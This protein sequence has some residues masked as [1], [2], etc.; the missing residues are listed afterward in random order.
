[1][2][3][4]QGQCLQ[5]RFTACRRAG[6]GSRGARCAAVPQ[7]TAASAPWTT[8]KWMWKDHTINYAVAGCGDPV[9]LIHGFGANCTQWR[10]TIAA[11]SQEHKVYA[12]DLLGFGGSEKAPIDYSIELWAEQVRDFCQEFAQTP[13]T[14][15]GNSIGSLVSLEAARMMESD[16]NDSG[17]KGLALINCAGGMNNKARTDDWRVKVALPLFLLIDFVLKTRFIAKP[18]FDSFRTE[19]NVRQVLQNVYCNPAE[20][21]DELVESICSPSDDPGALDVLVSVFT[22]PP[23]PKPEPLLETTET[24]VLILWGDTDPLT[25]VDGPVGQFCQQ[26]PDRRQNIQFQLLTGAG[27]C[28]MDDSPGDVHKFLLPWLVKTGQD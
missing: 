10:K 16:P 22:G 15:V 7:S 5:P 18:L 20:V 14:L 25:P 3:L 6:K 13:V 9:V 1:M 28:A 19:E 23:G 2:R 21:D 17:V 24:P 12:I 11:V 26:L 8:H 27:H 4:T